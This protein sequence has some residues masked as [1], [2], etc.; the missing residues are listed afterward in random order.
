M[1][2]TLSHTQHLLGRDQ[3]FI[4]RCKVQ[5]LDVA[6]DV[7]TETNV[8]HHPARANYAR[9]VVMNPD[10]IAAQAAQYLARSTNVTAAGIDMTDQGPLAKIDDAGLLSQVSSS[11]NILAG[12]DEGT[13]PA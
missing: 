10:G 13:G 6:D 3:V 7:L 12:I 11:W 2:M 5:L 4:S 9:S 1:P 8:P